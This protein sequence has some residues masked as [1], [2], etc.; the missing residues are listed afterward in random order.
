MEKK[1]GEK[2]GDKGGDGDEALGCLDGEDCVHTLYSSSNLC[3]QPISLVASLS[4]S[5][6]VT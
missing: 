6:R 2:R 4:R 3:G 1:D 5:L